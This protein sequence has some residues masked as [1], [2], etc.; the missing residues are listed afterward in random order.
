MP[1]KLRM[2]HSKIFFNSKSMGIMNI[3][4]DVSSSYELISSYII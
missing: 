4:L 1:D 2:R 3:P